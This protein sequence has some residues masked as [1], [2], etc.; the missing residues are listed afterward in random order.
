MHMFCF[1]SLSLSLRLTFADSSI[2]S[3]VGSCNGVFIWL[4]QRRPLSLKVEAAVAADAAET[5]IDAC[6]L[7][8]GGVFS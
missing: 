6:I 8:G 4:W 3:V 5:V 2:F 7:R 1:L